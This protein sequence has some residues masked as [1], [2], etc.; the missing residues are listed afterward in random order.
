[1]SDNSV[2]TDVQRTETFIQHHS[3]TPGTEGHL[4]PGERSHQLVSSELRV[5]ASEDDQFGFGFY[6][7]DDLF[8]APP[9]TN[10][11]IFKVAAV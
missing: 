5:V 10:Y 2:E 8:Q 7:F 9:S 4:V 11:S 1:M 3:E 6:E